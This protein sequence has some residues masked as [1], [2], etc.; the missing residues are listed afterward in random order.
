VLKITV[1]P[2]LM[3]RV[4]RFLSNRDYDLRLISSSIGGGISTWILDMMFCSNLGVCFPDSDGRIC[5]LIKEQKSRPKSEAEFAR[6]FNSI[7][8]DEATVIPLHHSGSLWI[9]GE[10]IS[11]REVSPVSPVPG[12]EQLSIK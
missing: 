1:L 4:M 6:D 5:N 11:S 7:L 10:A 9:F 12:I 8:A 2:I 3:T